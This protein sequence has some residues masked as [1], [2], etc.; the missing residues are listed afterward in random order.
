MSDPTQEPSHWQTIGAAIGIAL[1]AIAGF[2]SGRHR[3]PAAEAA[4]VAS[5]TADAVKSR[6]ESELYQQLIDRMETLE[7]AHRKLEHELDAERR[8]RRSLEDHV[9]LLERL[10]RAADLNPPVFQAF[11]GATDER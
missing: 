3:R 11:Q 10:M 9:G 2:F 4:E 1:S 8:L 5:F 6:A 7:V